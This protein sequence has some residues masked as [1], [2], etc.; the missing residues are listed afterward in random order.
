[1]R[2]VNEIINETEQTGYTTTLKLM[3]IM[4]E[5]GLVVRDESQRRH[6]YRAGQAQEATQQRLVRDLLDKAFGGSAEKLVMQA[7]S[8]QKVSP[9]ELAKIRELLD[10][11]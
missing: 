11:F 6:V 7:L 2:Q 8:A 4:T 9:E 1:M 5:K 10:K 3:Q